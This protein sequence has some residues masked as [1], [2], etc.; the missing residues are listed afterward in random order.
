[1][2]TVLAKLGAS[3]GPDKLKKVMAAL[4]A[5]KNFLEADVDD[6][7]ELQPGVGAH[8]QKQAPTSRQEAGVSQ[9]LNSLRSKRT[10]DTRPVLQPLPRTLQVHPS[11]PKG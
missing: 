6:V 1:M 11:E 4:D 5:L 2:A 9:M 8:Q 10:W 3:T 7:A